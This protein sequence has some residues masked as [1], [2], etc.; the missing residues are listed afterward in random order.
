[1]A[2]L[3]LLLLVLLGPGITTPV[4]AA[5]TNPPTTHLCSEAI[6]GLVGVIVAVTMILTTFAKSPSLR[7]TLINCFKRNLREP[8]YQLQ[9]KYREY[10]EFKELMEMSAM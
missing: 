4:F 8:V 9:R 1:M 10:L 2:P 5:P 3:A 6:N 7:R